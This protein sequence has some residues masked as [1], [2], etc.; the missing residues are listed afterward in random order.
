[1]I[2]NFFMMVGLPGSGKSSFIKTLMIQDRL[3]VHSSDEL[4]VEMFGDI[5]EQTKNHLLFKELHKRI[6]N[7][8]KAGKHTLFDATNINK[9]QRKRFLNLISSIDCKTICVFM[10][11]D[12]GECKRRN[13]LR[14]RKVPDHVIMRM[15]DQL[16][17]PDYHEDWDS[18]YFVENKGEEPCIRHI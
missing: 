18:I 1:M 10:N 9:K 2:P 4:R 7:D 17:I 8:L 16:Q 5:D 3:S 14:E 13:Q 15:A 11:T 12:I 6:I